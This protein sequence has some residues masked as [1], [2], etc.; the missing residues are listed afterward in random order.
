M[1]TLA[2]LLCLFMAAPHG[3]P[4]RARE[5]RQAEWAAALQGAATPAA[6]E[7]GTNDLPELLQEAL[8]RWTRED[9]AGESAS[10]EA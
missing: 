3:N 6:Q 9:P 4:D 7:P 10:D 2:T 1:R 5:G 8:R